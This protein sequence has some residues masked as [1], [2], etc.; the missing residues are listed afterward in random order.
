M[1][2]V[3]NA[4]LESRSARIDGEG[5][6]RFSDAPLEAECA[7]MD[8]SPLGLIA[9]AGPEAEDFLQGQVTNDVNQLSEAVSRLG[10]HCSPKGRMLASFR[11]F[12]IDDVF[13]LQLPHT[14][15]QALVQRLR[16]YLLRTKASIEDASDRLATI[17]IA[18]DCTPS[19]LASHLDEIPTQDNGMT[20]GR[21]LTAIRIPGPA[22]RFE[23]LG[24]IAAMEI[25]WDA[26]AETATLVNTD[27]WSLLDIRAG[28]PSVYP[29][30]SDAFVPQMANLQ[31]LDGVSFKKG[32]Y[33]GQEVVA[34]MQYLGKLKR[35][36]YLA[37]VNTEHPPVP[38][39]RLYCKSSN[40][41]QTSGRVVDARANRSGNCE[42]LVVVE[43]EAAQTGEVRLDGPNG[44]LLSF[45]DPPYGFPAEV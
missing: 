28:I 27:Y 4:F 11:A 12:R 33:T 40:S 6:V 18:G 42:L 3:W 10:S 36:M 17:A 45:S 26:L 16:M 41:E 13:Y 2:S 25:L 15:V 14:E 38:G 23:I 30:T 21:D 20:R 37:Q 44:P 29:Q 7:L 35:R 32:C 22:P 1:N 31:L 34:R 43:I 9:I 39:D 8:L 19:L 5:N 24:P